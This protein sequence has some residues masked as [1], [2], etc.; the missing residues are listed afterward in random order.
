MRLFFGFIIYALTIA[1]IV[2][3]AG[4]W[5]ISHEINAPGPLEQDTTYTIESGMGGNAIARGLE[6]DGII[7]NDL[8]FMLA[9][10]IKGVQ[11]DLKAGEYAFQPHISIAQAIEKIVSG[12]VVDRRITI[13]EGLTSY[14]IVQ[15][16]NAVEELSGDITVIPPE[17]ELLPN[18]YDYQKGED[19]NAV[20][21]RMREAMISTLKELLPARDADLPFKTTEEILTMASIVEKE[22]G[23]GGERPKIAAV[24]INRLKRG[25]PL[26]TDPTVIYAITL[27][28]HENNGQGPLGRRFLR[29][30]LDYDSPY[31]TYLYTG[32]PP[33][34]IANPGKAAI[35]AVLHPDSHDYIYFVADGTGGHVFA[36]TLDE[37]NKNVAKWRKIRQNR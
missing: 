2:S 36:E 9:V 25:M 1:I 7:K 3:A 29:K 35:E 27:G 37:H 31:N 16:L 11:N 14:Q 13:P 18:T 8:M 24:F 10:R 22:T 34:P 5:W 26:Q 33:T 23:V 17:G 28:K 12:D 6:R 15:R 4:F 30:D 21:K 19:R 20:I 32:L